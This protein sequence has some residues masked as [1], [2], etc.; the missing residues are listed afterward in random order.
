MS[1]ALRDLAKEKAGQ[2]VA[3]PMHTCGF[4]ALKG[5]GHKDLDSLCET[6]SSL[7]FELELLNV[8]QPGEYKKE[9]WAM[10]A[11]E[12]N[13]AIPDLREEGNKLYKEGKILEASEKYYE[14]LSYLEEMCIQEKPESDTWNAITERKIP[15][16]LNYAQCK[17]LL[18]EYADVIRHTTEVLKV[19]KVNVKALFRRGKAHSAFWNEK[20]ARED[21]TKVAQ[22][23]PSLSK[24]VDKELKSLSAR[25]KGKELA[26]R[27]QF[28]G[29]LF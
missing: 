16:L 29:K 11:A 28:S 1:K 21:L 13:A 4:G 12:K 19:D 25:L 15:F 7:I 17:L 5:T 24:A 6:N 26:D 10:T 27:K 22:L 23:D 18:C 9:H 2:T 3:P 8:I 14:A 20:E